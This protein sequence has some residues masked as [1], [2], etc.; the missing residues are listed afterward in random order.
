MQKLKTAGRRISIVLIP[1]LLAAAALTLHF[2]R[3]P[4]PKPP[5]FERATLRPTPQNPNRDNFEDYQSKV[6]GLQF[7]LPANGNEIEYKK[8]FSQE[9][10]FHMG[11]EICLEYADP[12]IQTEIHLSYILLDQDN[13][14]VLMRE[15]MDI[16]PVNIP[17]VCYREPIAWNAP[18]G[19]YRLEIRLLDTVIATGSFEVVP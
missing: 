10:A 11:W 18:I 7:Y 9:Q 1:I 17:A 15:D 19:F 13:L 16:A 8:V 2:G 12:D 3:Q 6:T 5:S 4:L 14:I